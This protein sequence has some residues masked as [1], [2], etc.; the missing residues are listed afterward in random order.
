MLGTAQ[1]RNAWQSTATP[2]IL[3]AVA[4][5]SEKQSATNKHLVAALQLKPGLIGPAFTNLDTCPR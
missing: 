1:P 2:L 3:G 5:F 4:E